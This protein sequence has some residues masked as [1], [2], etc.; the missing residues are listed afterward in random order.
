MAMAKDKAFCILLKIR[1]SSNL[2]MR[3]KETICKFLILNQ[4]K[5]NGE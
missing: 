2:S 4:I 1:I 5:E 3:E